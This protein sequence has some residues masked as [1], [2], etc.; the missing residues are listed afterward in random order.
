MTLAVMNR[1]PEGVPTGGQFAAQHHAEADVVLTI[2]ALT[3]EEA[4]N[5]ARNSAWEDRLAEVLEYMDAYGAMPTH[6]PSH[7]ESKRLAGWLNDQRRAKDTIP[8]RRAQLL[9]DNVPGWR[10]PREASWQ[11]KL[12]EIRD[13]REANGRLPAAGKES[14]EVSSYGRWLVYQRRNEN[15]LPEHRIRALD[16]LDRDWRDPNPLSWAK[17]VDRAAV[18]VERLGRFPTSGAQDPEEHRVAEWLSSQRTHRSR[19]TP[20]QVRE[21][22][23]RLPGWNRGRE[24]VWQ[25]RLSWTSE[26]C[27][28]NKRFPS[29]HSVNVVE[30]SHA[31]WV[32][33]QR[34]T[35]TNLSDERAAQLDEMLPGWRR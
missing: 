29:Q 7:H 11:K 22:D 13:Y 26:F 12:A 2:S 30:A 16:E 21:L 6:N 18:V 25:E 1:V 19:M 14:N 10:D 8:E 15:K 17:N 24:Q 33:A 4:G 23:T 27:R 20:E 35:A 9:D 28:R 31:A 34:R 3:G 32:R 5:A